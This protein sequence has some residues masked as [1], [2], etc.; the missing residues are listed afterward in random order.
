MRKIKYPESYGLAATFIVV[1]LIAGG[2]IAAAQNLNSQVVGVQGSENA[3]NYRTIV[4]SITGTALVKIQPTQAVIYIGVVTKDTTATGAWQKN[5]EI[6]TSVI[7]AL[8]DIGISENNIET[9]YYSLQPR[10][11]DYRHLRIIGY[12][13]T[14][15]LKIIASDLSK[16]GRA[17]DAA[18]GAGANRVYSITFT[19][20]D[21]EIKEAKYRAFYDAVRDA[22]EQVDMVA[23]AFGA[24]VLEV[25]SISLSPVY[26]YQL[27]TWRN[28][29]AEDTSIPT[30]IQP[31]QVGVTGYVAVGY[32]IGWPI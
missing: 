4:V 27:W 32:K 10:W 28:T 25:V 3:E 5:A 20:S 9:T 31:G 29:F 15:N 12:T 22:R 23:D 7:R 14:H 11:E 16:V 8:A 24:T 1:L 21:D 2:S 30:P 17:V 26:N 19:C 13:C 18:V 6:M